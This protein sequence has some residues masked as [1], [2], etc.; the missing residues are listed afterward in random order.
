MTRLLSHMI[1]IVVLTAGVAEA[2]VDFSESTITPASET[3][4]AGT[5][6]TVNVVLKNSGDKKSETTD[7]RIRFPHNGFLVQIDDLPG[8][9]RSDN[10]REVT[11]V[12][13]IPAGEEYRFTFSLLASRTAAQLTLSSDIEVR[14]FLA[15]ARWDSAVSAKIT[16]LQTNAGVVINGLRFH[17]AAGWLLGWI[18][19]CGLMFFW[20]RLRLQWVKDHPKANALAGDVLKMPA[21]ATVSVVMIPVAFLMVF[22]GMAWRDFQTLTSWKETQATILDRREVIKVD[23]TSEPGRRRRTSTTRTPEFAL[24]YQVGDHEVI[25]SGFDTGSSLHIGGQVMGKT[26]MDEWVYGKSIPCWYD[27]SNP[28]SVVVRRG[29]GGAYI[30]GLLPLPILWFGL[31]LLRTLGNTIRRLEESDISG[32]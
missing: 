18:A 3:V 30:F 32:N 9:K 6:L 26:E 4:P 24:K 15:E 19:A 1:L 7:L 21:M 31:R 29:F 16:N 28:G 13:S 12:L 25:S 14:D 23:S 27:P 2:K 8:L 20:V 22:A 11:A 17:P 5:V 10:E